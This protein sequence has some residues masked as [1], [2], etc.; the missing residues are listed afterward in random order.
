MNYQGAATRALLVYAARNRRQLLETFLGANRRA[1]ESRQP[2]AFVIPPAQRDP[3]VAAR[4]LRILREGEVELH[5]ARGP[6]TVNGRTVPAGAHVVLLQQP[7]SPFA[8]TLLERQRYPDLRIAPGGQPRQPYDS[9]A[10]TLPLLMGVEVLAT[11]SPV[12]GDLERDDAPRVRPGT[13]H[14]GRGRWLAIPHTVSGLVAAMRL[15]REKV[16]VRWAIAGFSEQGGDFPAGALL[17]PAAARSRLRALAGELGF[18]VRPVRAATPSLPMRLPRVGVYQ[19]WVPSMDEGWTRFVLEKQLEVPY[20]TLHDADVRKGR[21][22][23]TLDVVVLPD[24]S[25]AQIL[26][27][28]PPGS[29]PPEYTRGLGMEGVA[30][31]RSFVEQGGTLVAIDGAARFAID[32]LRLPVRD[33]LGEWTKRGRPVAPEAASEQGGAQFYGPGS[34]LEAQVA[35]DHPLVHG[36]EPSAAVWY[37]NGPGFASTADGVRILLRYP[38]RNPLLSGWL[39]GPE[40]IQGLG[41]LAEAPL[42]RGRVVLFGFRPQ[43]RAQSW[44]TYVLFLNAL[45]SSTLDRTS[46]PAEQ[47]ATSSQRSAS[48]PAVSEGLTA[49][50]GLR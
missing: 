48:E 45:F 27:G 12:V 11:D 14:R 24:H 33:A 32:Q 44:G 31:L 23:S 30:A 47:S 26:E 21:L 49:G 50:E 19:S 2:S 7:A 8:R 43:Y 6:L 39:I 36:A 38:A 18:D 15:I 42:G 10:H 28:H 25:P 4:L 34:L 46:T 22:E 40:K 1:S 17:A 41:A 20:R 13:L 9:T 3:A 35:G 37:D 29:L 5:R 16:P